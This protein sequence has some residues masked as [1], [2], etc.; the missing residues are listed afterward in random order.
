MART[1]RTW[2]VFLV[3]TGIGV[4]TSYL[5]LDKPIALWIHHLFGAT[6]VPTAFVESPFS[7]TSFI[8]AL[9]FV[10][11]GLVAIS[12]HRFSTFGTTIT[13][14]AIS[15]V[16][17]ILIKDQ[18]KFIFGRTWPDSW[19]QGILSLVR[20][21]VYGFHYFHHGQSFESF[22]SGHA[23]V[24]AATLSIP[25]ILA[26]RLRVFATTFIF[27]ADLGLVIL[28]LHFLSDVMAGTFLGV[29]IGLF[30][31]HLWRATC[32]HLSEETTPNK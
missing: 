19:G 29:S 25:W 26:P 8:S 3:L 12:G 24:A 20:N 9:I 11:C 28:N 18:L 23:A 27:A 4:G 2:L 17:T 32:W 1:L 13:M 16:S 22:P 5:W 6:H 10:V 7:S 15:A 21:G 30:T 14:C 31:I